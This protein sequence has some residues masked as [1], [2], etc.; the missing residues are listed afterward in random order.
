MKSRWRGSFHKTN[1]G[2]Y[3]Y[4]RICDVIIAFHGAD[5]VA[6]T[7]RD[8]VGATLQ[9]TNAFEGRLE[10]V[11]SFEELVARAVLAITASGKETVDQI[12]LDRLRQ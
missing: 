10:T 2:S 9:Y 11:S 7:D 6:F 12:M 3:T 1:T 5:I 4:V 8:G